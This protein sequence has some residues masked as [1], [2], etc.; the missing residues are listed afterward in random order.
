MCESAECG[1]PKLTLGSHVWKLEETHWIG[2]AL[3]NIVFSV[4]NQTCLELERYLQS[5][6]YVSATDLKFEGQED[7]WS[8]LI[9]ACGDKEDG[10][11]NLPSV[12][13]EDNQDCQILETNSMNSDASSEASD[14]SEELSPTHI[15][16]SNPLGSV[17]MESAHHLSS[18]IISTPP[19][20]PEM[21][22]EPCVTQVWGSTQ[23]DLHVP[24]KIRQN[25]LGKASDKASAGVDASTDGRRRVH[26]CHF[27]GCRKVYTKSSHLKAH[28]R[29]HTGKNLLCSLWRCSTLSLSNRKRNLV[30]FAE[31]LRLLQSCVM[32]LS[33]HKAVLSCKA[34]VTLWMFASHD[35]TPKRWPN[36]FGMQPWPGR[37]GHR[38]GE[39]NESQPGGKQPALPKQFWFRHGKDLGFWMGIWVAPF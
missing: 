5:E 33:S 30:R 15:F 1:K 18:S 25:G 4:L 37:R 38:M 20:S 34:N 16:T 2:H 8:K 19:S 32:K 12:K 13:E 36:L 27:N 21:P 23:T 39:G 9:L 14:S 22:Q 28:Q 11:G 3:S 35:R 10:N 6:P 17:L 26:R 24:V 29:T 31:V 7:L